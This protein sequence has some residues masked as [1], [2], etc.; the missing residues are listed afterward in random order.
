[1]KEYIV[2]Q[3]KMYATGERRNDVYGRMRTIAARLT[4]SR[5][6]DWRRITGPGSG[7]SALLGR[8]RSELS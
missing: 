4:R 6:T 2:A 1:V 7:S 5:S 8:K 3:L